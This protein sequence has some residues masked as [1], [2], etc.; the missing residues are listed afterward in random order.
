MSRG[1]RRKMWVISVVLLIAL[2]SSLLPLGF[3]SFGSREVATYSGGSITED[4]F[5]RQFAFQRRLLMPSFPTTEE[6]RR[7]FLEEYIVL[8]KVIV[9]KAKAEGITADEARVEAETKEYKQQLADL[10]YGGDVK[11][12]EA[13]MDQFGITMEDIREF[14]RH[15]EILR[16]YRDKQVAGVQVTDEE[17]KKYFEANRSDYMTGT[18][19]HVLVGTEDEAR[20][21]KDRLAAEPFDKVAK[22]MSLDPTAKDNGGKMENVEFGMFEQAFADA[23]AKAKP[24]E[25]YGPVKTTYGWHVLRVEHRQE[26]QFDEVAAEVKQ[27]ALEEKQNAAWEAV[28]QQ[29]VQAAGIRYL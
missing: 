24:G 16:K 1:N 23:A 10:V 12:V 4:E 5:E 26:K 25:L 9:E 20:K 3:F 29:H 14:I 21:A 8:H 6:N 27:A 28:Y 11:K 18:V 2:V 15:D 17:V 22:E 7:R 19:S 13:A